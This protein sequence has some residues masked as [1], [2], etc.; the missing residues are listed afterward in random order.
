VAAA[1]LAGGAYA[2][3]LETSIFAVEKLDV[4]G[5]TPRAQA[6]IRR[7]LAPELGRSLVRIGSAEIGGLVAPLPDVVGVTYDRRFPHTLH[8]RVVAERP[9]LLLRR[10]SDTWLVSARGRVLRRLGNPRLSSLPRVWIP[11][12][13]AVRVGEILPAASGGAAATAL[14]PIKPRSLVSGIRS[15]TGDGA[16]MLTLVLRSGLQ[17][18]LG[19]VGDL[20]LKLAIARRVLAAVRA[21]GTTAGYVD[22]SV[23]ERPVYASSNPQVSTGA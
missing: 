4:V 6:E 19:D 11:K 9:I 3:A 8:V 18:R 21:D 17:I 10:G 16:G 22:V 14:A 12:K 20:R 5:G 13:T 15:V 1:A 7:A 2:A 23:P